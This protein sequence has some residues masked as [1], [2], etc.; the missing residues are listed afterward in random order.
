[1]PQTPSILIPPGINS[2][3]GKVI[4]SAMR[5]NTALGP[6]L[7]ESAYE[8]CLLYELRKQGLRAQNQVILPVVY[9]GVTMDLGYR[10]DLLVED[11]V[12]DRTEVCGRSESG[13][14]GADPVLPETQRQA[15]RSADQFPRTTFK[16]GNP[17]IRERHTLAQITSVLLCALCG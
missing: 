13:A 8:A 15:S 12:G 10:M 16:R 3:T 4:G 17:Q 1:M 2:I 5:V 7:L 11:L 14:Q 9:E 6:G